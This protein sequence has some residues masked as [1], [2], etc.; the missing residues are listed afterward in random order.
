MSGPPDI[1]SVRAFWNE[2][3][4][5]DIFSKQTDRHTQAF[6]DDVRKNRKR[7]AWNI[8]PFVKQAAQSGHRILEIGC[9]VG[10]DATHFAQLGKDIVAIDL[11]PEAVKLAKYHFAELGVNGDLQVENAEQL[12]FED[13]IFDT[14]YSMGVLHH[15]PRIEKAMDEIFRVLKPGGKVYLMLY[16]KYSLNNLVHILF[17]IPYESPKNCKIDA[18][19]T[20][21]YSKNDLKKLLHKFEFVSLKKTYLF[22]AGWRP[23]SDLCPRLLNNLLGKWIGWHGMI[24]LQR[25]TTCK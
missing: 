8:D 23:L 16:S 1:D 21:R 24:V 18:P 15:T 6:L 12:N 19:V 13:G 4:N 2:N 14:V 5:G 3:V 10:V 11:A 9:G 7:Y 25:S 17:K 20:Y 22:G